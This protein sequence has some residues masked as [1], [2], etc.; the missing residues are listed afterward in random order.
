MSAPIN[1]KLPELTRDELTVVLKNAAYRGFNVNTLADAVAK[2]GVDKLSYNINTNQ[3]GIKNE[4]T[5]KLNNKIKL[6]KINGVEHSFSLTRFFKMKV[7]SCCFDKEAYNLRIETIATELHRQIQDAEQ[8]EA[9]AAKLL[10]KADVI[11]MKTI[12]ENRPSAKEFCLFDKGDDAPKANLSVQYKADSQSLVIRN[13]DNPSESL[14][15]PVDAT[16]TCLV[17]G[18]QKNLDEIPADRADWL[19]GAFKATVELSSNYKFENKKVEISAVKRGVEKNPAA[20]LTKLSD[21][22]KKAVETKTHPRLN[23]ALLRIAKDSDILT[24]DDVTRGDGLTRGKG[25]DNGG[26]S[27]DYLNSLF[28]SLI[29]DSIVLFKAQT[30]SKLVMPVAIQEGV[31]SNNPN[32]LFPGLTPSEQGVLSEMG[33]VMMFCYNSKPNTIDI[34]NNAYAIGQHFDDLLFEVALTLNAAAVDRNF[35]DVDVYVKVE[36][37]KRI[38]EKFLRSDPKNDVSTPSAIRALQE[39]IRN[40]L[41]LFDL[42][43]WNGGP[44]NGYDLS[45]L[46]EF[47][48]ED[49]LD[50]DDGFSLDMGKINTDPEQF[51]NAVRKG[52]LN[53]KL[54]TT[55]VAELIAPIHAIAQGMKS[56]CASNGQGLGVNEVWNNTL[57]LAGIRNINNKI[58]GSLDRNAIVASFDV[59]TQVLGDDGFPVNIPNSEIQ[60]LNKKVEWLKNWITNLSTEDA[61]IRKFLVYTTGSNSLPNGQRITIDRQAQEPYEPIPSGITCSCTL[62]VSPKPSGFKEGLNDWTEAA[63]IKMLYEQ[64][65][66]D[67]SFDINID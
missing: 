20:H 6:N 62:L 3:F 65:L 36:M 7:F 63:F 48:G 67:K 21:A 58:Q 13:V 8:K 66:N 10:P 31:S 25:L 42:F 61:A 52:L 30:P 28:T 47:A 5:G 27:R 24:P 59:K 39:K 34:K 40:K 1:K 60:E 54:G 46:A 9:A 23:V 35:A 64:I 51:V 29:E 53:A 33:R 2:N 14:Q 44:L 16:G 55:T 37:A 19:M 38:F 32:D 41:A 50:E 11:L 4:V 57:R 22:L 18:E 12:L 26:I 45:A 17:D 43:Q 49:F 15:F 56:I